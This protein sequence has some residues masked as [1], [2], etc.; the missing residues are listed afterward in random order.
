M[1][2]ELQH[3]ATEVVK[4]MKQ[5]LAVCYVGAVAGILSTSLGYPVPTM[6]L[7][8]A[9]FICI[10]VIFT[11]VFIWMEKTNARRVS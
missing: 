5:L 10:G 8:G 7:E 3:V 6:D 2:T 9:Y 1:F 11:K 4:V